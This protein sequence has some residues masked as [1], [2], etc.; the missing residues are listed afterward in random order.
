MNK[1]LKERLQIRNDI[2]NH[3]KKCKK[4]SGNCLTCNRYVSTF[5]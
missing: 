5:G 3:Y 2:E 1:R 4:T